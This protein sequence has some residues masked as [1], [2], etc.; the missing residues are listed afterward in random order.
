V[1][2]SILVA[3]KDS[4]SSKAAVDFLADL[5]L[6]P[7]D[8]RITLLHVFRKP[9]ASEELMGEDFAREA[10]VRQ[11]A[12]LQDARDRLLAEGFNPQNVRVALITDPYPTATEGIIDQFQKGNFSMV[13]IGRR[14]KS[15]SEEFVLG[16]VSVKLVR[17]LEGA[18]VLVVKTG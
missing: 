7:E 11:M 6:C 15:K 3:L 16:D 10:P 14:K 18:A 1:K 8:L 5:P 4:G 12:I 13:V 2:H 17:A 9:S